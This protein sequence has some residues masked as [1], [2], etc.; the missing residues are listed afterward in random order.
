TGGPSVSGSSQRR[1]RDHGSMTVIMLCVIAGALALALLTVGLVR[2][3]AARGHAQGAADLAALA[4]A[5]VAALGGTDACGTAQ[6]VTARNEARMQACSVGAGGMVTVTTRVPAQVLPGWARD[7]IGRARAGPVGAHPRAYS[8]GALPRAPGER[9]S[10]R[11]ERA[12]AAILARWN[13]TRRA[14]ARRCS[15]PCS[16][17][18]ASKSLSS[19]CTTS[20]PGRVPVARGPPGPI[21][22]WSPPTPPGASP[23]RGNTRSRQPKRAGPGATWSWP[24]PPGPANLWRPGYQPSA[25]SAPP[26]PAEASP[27][28]NA[29]PACSTSVPPKPWPR[30]NCTACTPC[31]PPAGSPTYEPPPAT[32]TPPP[33][34]APGYGTGPTWC[35]PTR[36][37]C[38][39]PYC[40]VTAAG[41]GCCAAC[42]TSSSTNATPTGAS[43]APTWPSCCAGCCGSPP[44]T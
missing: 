34:N 38:T 32:A 43:W 42:A 29:A 18:N 36:T 8:R 28:C 13:S 5:E 9:T 2:A 25:R 7:G 19:T 44:I 21:R 23:H 12:L 22:T 31:S 15:P 27:P 40:Q 30:T 33:T 11:R 41:S 17:P 10:V 35:S 6:A 26:R 3:Q 14:A 24:P 39:S 20:T 4:A 1:T 16:P 37:S